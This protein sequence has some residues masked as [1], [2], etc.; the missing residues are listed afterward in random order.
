MLY[1]F[2]LQVDFSKISGCIIYWSRFVDIFLDGILSRFSKRR[3]NVFRQLL[4]SWMYRYF[5]LKVIKTMLVRVVSGCEIVFY[6]FHSFLQIIYLALWYS[7]SCPICFFANF[8]FL[9]QTSFQ[10]RYSELAHSWN[11]NCCIMYQS[12]WI[13]YVNTFEG[14]SI[15]CFKLVTLKSSFHALSL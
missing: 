13:P 14:S 1:A 6:L 8:D 15:S 12:M 2:C 4:L 10:G 5:L 9:M 3:D 7:L 11:C